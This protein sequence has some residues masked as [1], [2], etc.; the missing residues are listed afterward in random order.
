MGKIILNIILVFSKRVFEEYLEMYPKDYFAYIYYSKVLINL[1]Y[2]N[3]ALK[4]LKCVK[5]EALIDNKFNNNTEI[6]NYFILSYRRDIYMD[7]KQWNTFNK[8]E[9]TH[10]IDVRDF[11][12][13]NYTPYT[14]DESF[15][16]GA[17]ERTL[18]LWDKSS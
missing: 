15:L 12:Q 10:E 5:E 14:G 2:F 9:W 4:V 7:F 13:K 8:G 17:T 1:G 6:F 3:D 18:K 16:S 11:I